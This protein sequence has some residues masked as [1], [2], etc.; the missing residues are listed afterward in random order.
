MSRCCSRATTSPE[1]ISNRHDRVAVPGRPVG[2]GS[3]LSAVWRQLRSHGGRFD[4]VE[5]AGVQCCQAQCQCVIFT[6]ATGTL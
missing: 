6:H 5:D 2:M 3:L 1:P 4:G